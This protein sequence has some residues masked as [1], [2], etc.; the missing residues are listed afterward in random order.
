MTPLGARL[1]GFKVYVLSVLVMILAV[2]SGWW[3]SAQ[4]PDTGPPLTSALDVLPARSNVVG[5]T[6][7]AQIRESLD[8]GAIATAGE[9]DELVN[10][11]SNRDLSTRSV[12]ADGAAAMDDV[13]GWSVADVEW[14]A[15]GQHPR[16]AA[17][18]VRLIGSV[19]FD[20]IRLRL[21]AAEYTQDGPI[22]SA[23]GR[24][25]LP[26]ILPNVALVPNERLVVMSESPGQISPVLDVIDGT[27]RSL[28]GTPAAAGTAEALAGS[29]SVIL[30]GATLGCDT[31]AVGD[32]PDV[33]QQARTAVERA[34]ALE[35]YRYSGRGIVDRGG[36]GFSAQRLVFAMT[37]S[38]AVVASEQAD[39]REQLA[40]GP[41]IGRIG[42]IEETL[43]LRSVTTDD[44]TLRM[45]FDHDPE[46]DVFM[47]GRGPL[48]F[49][50]C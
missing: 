33:Q 29:A 35:P 21:R 19:S 13:L 34:G 48:L 11:A 41:F 47:T 1:P 42:Q 4:R 25:D 12:I 40:A 6:D 50:A 31:S 46:T 16:G 2:A 15:Y 38:S 45:A 9:R 49:A 44:S 30:Q 24:T 28:G 7:W 43:R 39:V 22:W 26:G 27:A 37:F 14:E 18:V 36:L 3:A 5:F 20:D 23:A 8:L 10:E 17:A 32:E